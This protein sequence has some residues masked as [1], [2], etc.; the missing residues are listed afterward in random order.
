MGADYLATVAMARGDARRRPGCT[1]LAERLWLTFGL[2]A[3]G[4]T[5]WPPRAAWPRPNAPAWCWATRATR[6]AFEEG[7]AA[8]VEEVQERLSS[9]DQTGM[10]IRP[11]RRP[12]RPPSSTDFASATSSDL[13][14][15]EPNAPSGSR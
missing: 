8:S 9:G 11:A 7:F 5:N 10:H 1:A 2:T 14:F 6:A 4:P 15:V 13:S 3:M 12:F